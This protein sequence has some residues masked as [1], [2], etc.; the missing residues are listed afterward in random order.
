MH[1]GNDKKRI[2]LGLINYRD[3][4]SLLR[5]TC[6]ISPHLAVAVAT[7]A[8]AAATTKMMA[9]ITPSVA[10]TLIKKKPSND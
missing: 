10:T 2:N 3:K 6:T 5:L 4:S 7:T 8:A 9:T 1:N